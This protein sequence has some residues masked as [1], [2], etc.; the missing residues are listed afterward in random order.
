MNLDGDIEIWCIK[1]LIYKQN[2]QSAAWLG[3]WWVRRCRVT[4]TW[5]PSPSCARDPS[6]SISTPGFPLHW[7]REAQCCWI[8]PGP[9]RRTEVLAIMEGNGFP[10]ALQP[11]VGFPHWHLVEQHLWAPKPLHPPLSALS[12]PISTKGR[13]SCLRMAARLQKV[14]WYKS[15]SYV[16]KKR[17]KRGGK[18]QISTVLKLFLKHLNFKLGI[19]KWAIKV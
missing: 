5:T 16:K 18:N 1:V 17:K 14:L 19:Y 11:L 13:A 8:M 9:W 3:R 10:A 4:V 2:P 7:E 12:T 6:T 15:V